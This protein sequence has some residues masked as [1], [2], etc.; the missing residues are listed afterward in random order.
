[1]EACDGSEVEYRDG[2]INIPEVYDENGWT[3]EASYVRNTCIYDYNNRDNPQ[4]IDTS[5]PCD[6]TTVIG[7]AVVTE[8]TKQ[9]DAQIA[10]CNQ[11]G[12]TFCN[13]LLRNCKIDV[14]LLINGNAGKIVEEVTEF[15]TTA[16]TQ[17]CDNGFLSGNMGNAPPPELHNTDFAFTST[18]TFTGGV[19]MDI[20]WIKYL[21]C[22]EG[23][24]SVR[25]QYPFALSDIINLAQY[26]VTIK[27]LPKGDIPGL[28]E[29]S[30]YAVMAD[31][32]SNPVYAMN[33]GKEMSYNLDINTGLVDGVTDINNWIGTDDAVARMQN[34]CLGHGLSIGSEP[35]DLITGL[36]YHGSC[37]GNGLHLYTNM[38]YFEY[39][40]VPHGDISIWMGF[41][42]QKNQQCQYTQT[43]TKDEL[44][45]MN[46]VPM[47]ASMDNHILSIMVF[48]LILLC[49]APIMYI[50]HQRKEYK[51]IKD[52]NDHLIV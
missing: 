42:K 2:F 34:K 19:T 45:E 20:G 47:V 52:G 13:D 31:L 4:G 44:F 51:T 43:V 1:M 36:F 22:E 15:M 46:N 48:V 7:Q 39:K 33:H 10:C 14:C 3:W 25:V 41:H 23:E 8:C 32:C 28:R 12:G 9:Y 16:I 27:I 6:P 37:N 30:E 17:V 50:Y 18:E 21:S 11:I 5:D 49:I 24:G 38:C 26:A 35:K 29:D 40:Q